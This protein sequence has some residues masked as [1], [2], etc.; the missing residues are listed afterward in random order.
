MKKCILIIAI[1][2]IS[3]LAYIR[4]N[5]DNNVLRNID[6]SS[7]E[8]IAGCEVESNSNLNQG[9]CIKGYN[10]TEDQCMEKGPGDAV[11]CSGTI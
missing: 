9:Y 2:I 1:A 6:I 10:S 8:A 4:S 7:V 11:R 5:Q 3:T